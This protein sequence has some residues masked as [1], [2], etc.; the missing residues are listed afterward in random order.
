MM[1][2]ISAQT[3]STT[4]RYD[5]QRGVAEVEVKISLTPTFEVFKG[6]TGRFEL[7]YLDG[8]SVQV[9]NTIEELFDYLMTTDLTTH[10]YLNPLSFKITNIHVDES[11]VLI[12][13]IPLG[14]MDKLITRSHDKVTAHKYY[15]DVSL[16]P[17]KLA[18]K[19]KSQ[20]R[21]HLIQIRNFLDIK[22][23]FDKIIEVFKINLAVQLDMIS[24]S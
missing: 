2:L 13:N 24:R 3:Y 15:N 18:F 10:L 4:Y 7:Q 20:K 11:D 9:Y 5:Y 12:N 16:R 14:I 6:E 8:K 17:I 21:E 23:S 22:N 19:S 1:E